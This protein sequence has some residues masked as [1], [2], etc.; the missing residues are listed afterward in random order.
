MGREGEQLARYFYLGL[1][2]SPL[3]KVDE[4]LETLIVT[5]VRT[6]PS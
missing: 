1:M 2:A 4:L 3:F 5:T 6:T